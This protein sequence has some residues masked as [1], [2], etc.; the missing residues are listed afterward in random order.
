VVGLFAPGLVWAERRQSA[1]IQD[2]IGPSRASIK[3][4]GLELRLAG[5]LHPLADAMKLLFK[6]DFVPPGADKLL[7]G[8]A[9]IIT[10]T[11][12]LLV[13]AA[14]PFGDVIHLDYVRQV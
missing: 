4:F 6:E 1:M 11:P 13:L 8:L 3:L 10:M 9:P 2:R 5:F 14:I 7:H 12:A